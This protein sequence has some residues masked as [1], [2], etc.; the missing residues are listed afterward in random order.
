MIEKLQIIGEEMYWSRKLCGAGQFFCEKLTNCAIATSQALAFSL[1]FGWIS[2][3]LRRWW[4]DG[5]GKR[6]WMGNDGWSALSWHFNQRSGNSLFLALILSRLSG[7]IVSRRHRGTINQLNPC[8]NYFYETAS[9][10]RSL[11]AYSGHILSLLWGGVTSVTWA[12]D[13]TI[14]IAGTK[15]HMR[16]HPCNTSMDPS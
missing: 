2:L 8:S 7:F 14:I 15:P 10:F 1:T 3:R 4:R 13:P 16:P 5:E 9:L 12:R 6:G 11:C